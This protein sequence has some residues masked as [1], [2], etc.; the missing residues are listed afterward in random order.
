MLSRRAAT[1][2]GVLLA[3]AVAFVLGASSGGERRVRDHDAPASRWEA[4]ARAMAAPWPA[5]QE[6]SGRLGDYTDRLPGAFGRHGGTRYGDAVMGYALIEAGLRERDRRLVRTGIRAISFA[7]DPARR[8]SRPSVFEQ[9]AVAAA[10]NVARRRLAGEPTLARARARWEAWLRRVRIVELQHVDRYYNHWLVDA[11]A[12]LELQRTGLRSSSRTA[13]LGGG[14]SRARRLALD[15]VNV[16]IPGLL[17]ARG[18]AV[19]SDAPDNPLSYHGLSLGLYARAVDLLGRDAAPAARRVLRQGVWAAALILAPNGSLGYIGRSQEEV[20]APAGAAYA[21]AFTAQRPGASSAVA[22]VAG[23]VAHR[24]LA[25]L[26]RAYPVGRDGVA[27]VPAIGAGLR[28]GW[29]GLDGYAGAPSM[30]GLALMMLNWTLELRPQK[31]PPG[32][33]PADYP[34]ATTVSQDRGRLAVVRRG[35]TWFAV[36][37]SRSG[38]DRYRGDL[39]YDAGLAYAL[40]RVGGR[41]RELVPQRPRTELAERATAGP[42]LLTGGPG[43]FFGHDID[44]AADGTVRI[45]GEYR[46]LVG[47]LRPAGL[48]YRPLRCGVGLEL[49]ARAGDAYRM[50]VFFSRRPRLSR[51]GA[52]DGRQAVTVAADEATLELAPG[53]MAS[54]ERARLW[55]VD[56]VLGAH[57]ARRLGVRFCAE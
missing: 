19:L 38:S 43:H 36:K 42:L 40:R 10:Y 54:G 14:A 29:R 26:E 21:A 44:A 57:G 7:T 47:S 23:T 31:R 45:T 55:R 37:M 32:R 39:R 33:L 34:L 25:R 48:V 22:A 41:W 52:R 2:A 16:R 6:P 53:T 35:A 15:L 1:G 5:L 11:V 8:P 51:L 13:V 46:N 49:D 27:I 20:W 4:L 56:M 24:S 17:P 30:G 12:V 18:A 9:F 50:S 28:A 3:L